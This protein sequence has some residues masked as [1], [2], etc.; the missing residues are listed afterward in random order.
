[1]SDEAGGRDQR[2]GRVRADLQARRLR[3]HVGEQVDRGLLHRLIGRVRVG[4][5]PS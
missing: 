1:M 3:A 4:E 5:P 2:P